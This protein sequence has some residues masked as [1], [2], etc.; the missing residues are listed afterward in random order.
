MAEGLAKERGE[1]QTILENSPVGS[2]VGNGV[3]ERAIKEV[4]YQ[5]RTLKSAMETSTGASSN[6]LAWMIEFS[7]VLLKGKQSKMLG[8]EFAEAVLFRKVATPSKFGKLD[9]LEENGTFIGYRSASRESI[10]TNANGVYKTL[11]IRRVTEEVR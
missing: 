8:F 7:S 9:S 10:V 5:V 6:I 1:A 2:S 11:A 4:E 3:I